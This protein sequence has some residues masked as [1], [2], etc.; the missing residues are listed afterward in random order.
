MIDPSLDAA[1]RA[2]A[3]LV[4][5]SPA[6]S[7][8]GAFDAQ[9]I[10]TPKDQNLVPA[11]VLLQAHDPGQYAGIAALMN[12]IVAAATAAYWQR[13]HS[14]AEVGRD[15][16]ERYGW[17][18]LVGP[19]GHFRSDQTRAYISCWG[20]GLYYSWHLH[21]AEELYFIL[22]G[23]AYFEADGL[24]PALLGP[25]DTRLHASNQPHAMTT[26]DRPVLGLVLWRGSG[27]NGALRMGRT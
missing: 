24:E 11:A 2:L 16:L 7:A 12:A 21:E 17:F 4:S 23:S 19:G 1:Y 8:F 22:A 25:G 13:T 9:A 15:F 5:R 6:L 3:D 27:M 10:P 18:E 26:F 20:E 14:E